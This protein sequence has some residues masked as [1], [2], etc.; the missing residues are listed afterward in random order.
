MFIVLRGEKA[1]DMCFDPFFALQG[2]RGDLVLP[3]ER[4]ACPR[5][6]GRTQTV[7]VQHDHDQAVGSLGGAGNPSCRPIGG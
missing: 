2:E 3:Q 7:P 1:V 5:T 4:E 6:T